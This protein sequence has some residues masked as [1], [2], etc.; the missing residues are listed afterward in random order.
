MLEVQG[1]A[2][3]L[4]PMQEPM[5]EPMQDPELQPMQEPMQEPMQDPELQQMQEQTTEAP[6][7]VSGM[8][9]T[10][11]FEKANNLPGPA[12]SAITS[13]S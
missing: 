1:G 7:L 13:D 3:K 6:E 12:C 9:E 2:A 5:Q 4:Q 11:T 8:C 10:I